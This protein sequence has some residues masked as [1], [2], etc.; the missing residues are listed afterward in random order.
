[1]RALAQLELE[2][3]TMRMDVRK[4]D[5]VSVMNEDWA[6]VLA[7][8][9]KGPGLGAVYNSWTGPVDWTGT[10]LNF[11]LFPCTWTF[12]WPIECASYIVV[13]T[14]VKTTQV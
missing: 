11:R 6:V 12:C 10:Q 8:R 7:G 9:D 4:R 1:M 3:H 2:F 5:A 13:I 14:Q